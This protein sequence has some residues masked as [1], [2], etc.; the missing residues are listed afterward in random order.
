[1]RTHEAAFQSVPSRG[2]GSD[3]HRSP[4]VSICTRHLP[5]PPSL[6]QVLYILASLVDVVQFRRWN[7]HY[8]IPAQRGGG[9]GGRRVPKDGASS[10]GGRGEGGG[11]G[12]PPPFQ[13]REERILSPIPPP[14]SVPLPGT[15]CSCSESTPFRTRAPGDGGTPPVFWSLSLSKSVRGKYLRGSTSRLACR[16]LQ[17]PAPAAPP[18]AC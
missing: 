3:P 8:G 4:P 10:G 16:P 17:Q 2:M 12:L 15:G 18:A 13:R 1:L 6:L 9:R 11:E 7:T 14:P 5:S